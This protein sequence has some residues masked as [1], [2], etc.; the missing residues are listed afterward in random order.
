M[1][2][3]Q[4]WNTGAPGFLNNFLVFPL[5][6]SRDNPLNEVA[7]LISDNP[8][9][10]GRIVSYF[11]I[12]LVISIPWLF[13]SKRRACLVYVIIDVLL[14]VGK[15]HPV[16]MGLHQQDRSRLFAYVEMK[17]IFVLFVRA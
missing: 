8:A 13:R 1:K 14:P 12:A 3:R 4:W 16:S 17:E 11:P 7:G 9:L 5:L 6:Y 10:P 2:W 15:N